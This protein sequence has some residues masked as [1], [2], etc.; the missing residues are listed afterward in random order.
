MNGAFNQ[1]RYLN[2][3]ALANYTPDAYANGLRSAMK[4]NQLLDALIST[5][6]V[7]PKDSDISALFNQTRTV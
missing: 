7:I 2:I 1:E 4:K 3:L 6:F 5:N